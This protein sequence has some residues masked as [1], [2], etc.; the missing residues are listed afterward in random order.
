VNDAA[1]ARTALP[2]LPI[3][4]GD[5]LYNLAVVK[6]IN[7]IRAGTNVELTPEQVLALAKVAQEAWSYLDPDCPEG[8]PRP[9]LALHLAVVFD[10]PL[11][12]IDERIERFE[13][14]LKAKAHG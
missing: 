13:A 9:P 11:A 5:C 12:E 2:Q 4:P 14:A 3:D 8:L 7:A 10:R 6:A 1:N